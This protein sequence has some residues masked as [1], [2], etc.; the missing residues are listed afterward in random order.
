MKHPSPALGRRVSEARSSPSSYS[1]TSQPAK[2]GKGQG[3]I[4]EILNMGHLALMSLEGRC[5]DFFSLQRPQ[6]GSVLASI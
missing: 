1:S 2:M 4:K 5:V 6:I 3:G